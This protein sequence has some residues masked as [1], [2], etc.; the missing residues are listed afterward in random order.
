MVMQTGWLGGVLGDRCE[1]TCA[2]SSRAKVS[3]FVLSPSRSK[4][5]DNYFRFVVSGS[6]SPG[7]CA[8]GRRCVGFNDGYDYLDVVRVGGSKLD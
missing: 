7:K 2:L 5:F 6:R 3:F 1:S 4:R 8:G